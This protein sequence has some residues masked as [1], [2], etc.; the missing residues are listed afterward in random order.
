M[1]DDAET[2]ADSSDPIPDP[3]PSPASVFAAARSPANI[4]ANIHAIAL[5]K[6][7]AGTGFDHPMGREFLSLQHHGV[8]D[9]DSPTQPTANA[10][11]FRAAGDALTR[12]TALASLTDGTD[13]DHPLVREFVRRQPHGNTT[14]SRHQANNARALRRYRRSFL[15]SPDSPDLPDPIFFCGNHRCSMTGAK[16]HVHVVPC[17]RC[18]HSKCRNLCCN[19]AQHQPPLQDQDNQDAPIPTHYCSPNCREVDK[20]PHMI[21]AHQDPI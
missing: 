11:R 20:Q 17:P 4:A 10:A 15:Y 21:L 9:S 12:T 13:F 5:A 8:S 7:I 1:N 18:D 14:P 6:L 2:K 3:Q 19:D 16:H